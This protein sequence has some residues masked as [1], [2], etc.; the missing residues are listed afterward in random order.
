M[1]IAKVS[2]TYGLHSIELF[3]RN[4]KYTEVQ[5]PIEFCIDH[6]KIYTMKNDPYNIDRHLKSQYLINDG[7][8]LRIY[9]SHNHSNGIGFIINP[10]T[11]LSGEYQPVRLWVPTE[12][13]VNKLL[14][15][16]DKILKS[17]GLD[18]V[19]SKDLSLSQM[20]ITHNE[21]GDMVIL[22]R[23]SSVCFGKALFLRISRYT[24]IRT[25]L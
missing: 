10:S 12:E 8:R 2:K 3:A 20:D 9:Q 19:K 6:G 4:L 24:I 21:W 15:D 11:L 7:I 13:A 1:S 18:N 16:F 22:L 5:K 14:K 17:L 25:K 23:R